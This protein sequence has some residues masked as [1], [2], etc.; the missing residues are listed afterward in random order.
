MSRQVV[1]QAISILRDEHLVE[2]LQGSGTYVTN[3]LSRESTSYGVSVI[4]PYDDDYIFGSF[5]N[6]IH[7]TLSKNG[8]IVE[9]YISHNNQF[10]EEAAIASILNNPPAGIIIDPAK[11]VFPRLHSDLYQKIYDRRIP[12]VSIN[13]K[14]PGFDFPVVAMDDVASARIATKYLLANG[15]TKIGFLCNVDSVP[16]QLR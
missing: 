2:S 5:I 8:Y 3:S 14:V 16:G 6:G 13:C 1:R 11:S 4:L 12:C 9:M 15:H 7:G 10:E